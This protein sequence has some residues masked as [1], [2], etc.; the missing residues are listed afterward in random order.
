MALIS[1][2]TVI[3]EARDGSGTLH[4]AWEAIRLGRPLFVMQSI[5]DDRDLHWPEQ[6]L[7]YGAEVLTK[8]EQILEV[9]PS[10]RL[11][12]LEDAPF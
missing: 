9:L 10:R 6:I 8:T 5:L 12:T 11:H 4:Q 1:D 3:V 2:A 7:D